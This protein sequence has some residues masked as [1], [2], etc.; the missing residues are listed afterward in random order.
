MLWKKIRPSIYC[1]NL[2]LRTVRECG[3]GPPE[4]FQE[5]LD[6]AKP[7]PK[8]SDGRGAGGKKEPKAETLL[9][10]ARVLE[11]DVS[12]TVADEPIVAEGERS[13][14][15]AV[16]CGDC[17]DRH[18]R[19]LR[20][21]TSSMFQRQRLKPLKSRSSLTRSGRLRRH[22]AWLSCPIFCRPASSTRATLLVLPKSLR[23]I[24]GDD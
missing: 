15:K 19:I 3:V 2:F 18:F 14:S 13:Q 4:L 22:L 9:I 12:S 23:R 17:A 24:K 10:K 11:D 16:S 6:S 1:Y 8:L 5:L 7:K 20:Y 21:C